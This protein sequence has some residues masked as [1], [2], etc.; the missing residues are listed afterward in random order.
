[1][2]E[3]S[4]RA[5][6][7][8]ELSGKVRE[9]IIQKYLYENDWDNW[10]PERNKSFITI[11]EMLEFQLFSYDDDKGY[12][13][14]VERFNPEEVKGVSRVVAYVVN[15]FPLKKAMWSVDEKKTEFYKAHSDALAL[16][17]YTLWMPTGY[18]ADFALQN[19][20]DNFVS[21]VRKSHTKDTC[22]LTNFCK[23]LEGA[24]NEELNHDYEYETSDDFVMKM[25]SDDW[26]AEDGTN[27]TGLVED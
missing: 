21:W 27:I 20:V 18:V 15:R 12:G 1:M 6:R 4:I 13:V 26:F 24:F 9:H 10:Y 2:E 8:E 22:T 14:G 7:I 17:R 19:A 11:C 25:L 5:Y 16:N 23:F 3:K